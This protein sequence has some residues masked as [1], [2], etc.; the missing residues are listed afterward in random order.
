MDAHVV[1]AIKNGS[2]QETSVFFD[3]EVAEKKKKT[4]IAQGFF[5]HIETTRIEL[6]DLCSACK[7]TY[8]CSFEPV[9]V[10]E[11]IHKEPN[12]IVFDKSPKSTINR[13]DHEYKS[14]AMVRW[15]CR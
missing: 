1:I 10:K 11:S 5:V 14:P 13:S 4:L 2:I 9:W 3:A 15:G 8:K 6:N 7:N 12:V